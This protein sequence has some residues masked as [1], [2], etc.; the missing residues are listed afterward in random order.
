MAKL[1]VA[2][3]LEMMDT[4][5]EVSQSISEEQIQTS[6]PE[7]LKEE[8]VQQLDEIVSNHVPDVPE[9]EKK[10]HSD[11]VS[12]MQPQEHGAQ[13]GQ[14]IPPFDIPHQEEVGNN[15]H[16]ADAY[17]QSKES[18]IQESVSVDS[19]VSQDPVSLPAVPLVQ[20]EVLPD[21]AVPSSEFAFIQGPN[22]VNPAPS[23]VQTSEDVDHAAQGSVAVP[24]P[25][26][27]DKTYDSDSSDDDDLYSMKNFSL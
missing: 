22:S 17:L 1:A 26:T 18:D 4:K 27:E 21:A 2:T 20:E 16:T 25:H 23:M 5:P 9:V 14:Q 15:E 13:T 19:E 6:N 10:H 3:P 8:L 24:D 11:E 7:S 12:D